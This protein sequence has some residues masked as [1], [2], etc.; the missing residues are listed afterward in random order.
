MLAK[1]VKLYATDIDTGKLL[2]DIITTFTIDVGMSFGEKKCAYICIENGKRKSLGQ[3][4]EINGL[5]VKEL[6]EEQL[7][8]YLGQDEA[9]GYN[10]PLNKEKVIKEYKRRVCKIWT[11]E[12]YSGNKITAHNTFAVPLITPTIGIL[13]WTRKETEDL[14]KAT[15]RIM[16]YTGNLHMRSDIY[17]LRKQ[18]GRGLASIEDTFTSRIVALANHIEAAATSNPFLE[19]VKEHEQNNIVRLRD[20]LLQYHDGKVYQV[21]P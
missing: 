13:N 11:S 9:V 1:V 18:R 2:L 15:R 14:D 5:R 4:I 19:K 3:T 8:T 16:C 21:S 10:G 7:Y 20:Q 12:L 17:V 6:Q